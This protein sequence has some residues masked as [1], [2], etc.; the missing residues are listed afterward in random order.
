MAPIHFLHRALRLPCG[1]LRSAKLVG[2]AGELRIRKPLMRD[3]WLLVVLGLL[4][5]AL[6]VRYFG[7]RFGYKEGI[8]LT[9]TVVATISTVIL[10]VF[11]W[12]QLS[13]SQRAEQLS[14]TAK[15]GELRNCMWELMDQVPP[16]GTGTLLSLSTNERIQWFRS[17]RRLLDS[18]I[19]NPVLLA[20]EVS[21]GYWRN[22]ISTSRTHGN[23]ASDILAL[24]DQLFQ[25]GVNS[26]Y[27]DVMFVWKRLV[28]ESDQVSPTGGRP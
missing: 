17:V 26:I 13:S 22:A 6:M 3:L 14:E 11:A 27:S 10:G 24:D 7:R 21:L 28:L 16:S 15:W 19:G 20:D 4:G 2:R 25:A 8:Q 12:Q 9:S 18:Q 5:L 23:A 1:S